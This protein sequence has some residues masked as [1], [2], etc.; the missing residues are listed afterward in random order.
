MSA[1]I[2]LRLKEECLEVVHVQSYFRVK[3]AI[4]GL[5]YFPDG[6]FIHL[7]TKYTIITAG[8]TKIASINTI[9]INEVH[10]PPALYMTYYL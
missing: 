1:Q 5:V 2:H 9:I 3:F 6:Q 8:T 7:C 10:I 4:E